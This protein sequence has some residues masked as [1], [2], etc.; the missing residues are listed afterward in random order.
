VAV[1]AL[2]ACL[3]A[4]PAAVVAAGA[5]LAADATQEAAAVVAVV[6][7]VIADQLPR[8]AAL[9]SGL[10]AADRVPVPPPAALRARVD[11]GHRALAWLLAGAGL[12]LAG[13][14]TAL[15]LSPAPLAWVLCAVTA[16]A[17]GLRA[18]RFRFTAEVVPLAVA[19][20]AGLLALE[21]ALGRWLRDRGTAG[22]AA[23]AVALLL[24][25]AA[26]ALALA[27]AAPRLDGSSPRRRRLLDL[28]ELLANLALVLLVTGVLGFFTLVYQ[29]AH[30]LA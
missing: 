17:A 1:G 11:R 7:L 3:A 12:P 26:V 16:L 4:P 2:A 24:G 5:A 18:R 27:L 23:A 30:R 9:L 10:A 6:A 21:A 19:A 15:A 29:V 8:A 13:A 25:T 14:L 20:L 22:S 28:L